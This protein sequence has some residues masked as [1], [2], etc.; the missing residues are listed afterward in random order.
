MFLESWKG[1]AES[2]WTGSGSGVEIPDIPYS[3]GN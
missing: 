2:E 1:T 3:V